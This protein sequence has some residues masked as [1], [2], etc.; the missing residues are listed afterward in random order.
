MNNITEIKHQFATRVVEAKNSAELKQLSVEFLGKN[1]SVTQ[2]LK[3]LAKLNGEEKV[4][5][6]KQVNELKSEMQEII[7]ELEVEFK[8]NELESKLESEKI[9]ITK[10]G[11]YTDNGELHPLTGIT[12][13]IVNHFTKQGYDVIDGPEIENDENNFTLLNIPEN[14]S[15]RDMQDSF[16]I[17]EGNLLRTHTSPTQIR[18]MTG[19]KI[20]SACKVISPGVVYRRDEDDATHSHQFMQIEGLVIDEGVSL[21]NLKYVLEELVK[22]LFGDNRTIRMR[23]SYFPFTEPSM[24]VD[25]DCFGCDGE[26]CNICKGTGWIEV[27]G[28][29]MVHPNVLKNCDYDTEKYSGFA[30]GIGVERIAMLKYGVSDIRDF[31]TND[32]RFLKE[33]KYLKGGH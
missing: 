3:G 29:G 12:L 6:A 17:D 27:L 26:G 16:Y 7:S 2:L 19:A 14:H 1:G 24:E 23:P 20:K 33:F 21:A 5:Y 11:I 30:F 28:C 18:Y 13:Q 31:Y 32:I 15:A 25:V 10:P 8:N 22:E 9:D 4:K